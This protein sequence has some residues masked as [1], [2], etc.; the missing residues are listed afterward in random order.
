V[1][2]F[3]LTCRRLFFAGIAARIVAPVAPLDA[4]QD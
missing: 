4:V 1:R 2:R 3:S